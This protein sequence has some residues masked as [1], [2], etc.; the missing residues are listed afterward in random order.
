MTLKS[1]QQPGQRY[2]PTLFEHI[3]EGE[4]DPAFLLTH[5]MS[6]EDGAQGY[7]LKTDNCLRVVFKP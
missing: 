6:L 5:P 4:L 2:A 3:R 1:G 7:E